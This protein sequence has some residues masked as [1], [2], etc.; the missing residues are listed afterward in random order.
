SRI[1]LPHPAGGFAR[2]SSRW[3]L[4]VRSVVPVAYV[5]LVGLASGAASPRWAG[6]VSTFPSMATVLLTVTHLEEG[7][8][9]ASRIARSLPT[10]NLSTAAFLAAFRFGCPILGPA[11]ATL[12]GYLAALSNLAAVELAHTRLDLKRYFRAESARRIPRTA[13]RRLLPI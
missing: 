5:L 9:E 8:A 7:P 13:I 10:A 4:L 2:Q 6:L 1:E 3:S 12:L 11:W